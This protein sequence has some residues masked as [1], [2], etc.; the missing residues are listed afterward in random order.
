[1]GPVRRA[2]ILGLLSVVCAPGGVANAADALEC[3]RLV[4]SAKV[5]SFD[6]TLLDATLTVPP[7]RARPRPLIVFLHGLLADKK[8]YLSGGEPYKTIHWNNRWFAERGYVVL[9]YSARGHGDSGG[10]IELA[11]RHVEVRDTRFLVGQLVD[12][13][14]VDPR[15]MAVLGSSYGGG[16]A[17]LLM[18][19]REG[20]RGEYGTWRSPRGK[21]ISLAAVVPQYTW[22]DLVQSLVPNGRATGASPVGVPKVTLIDGFLASAGSRLPSYA[23]RWLSRTTAGEPYEGDPVIAEAIHALSVDRS[24]WYQDG[25]FARLRA[26]RQRPVPVFAAQGLTDPVFSPPGGGRN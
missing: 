10:E 13:G 19:T 5:P 6:G 7:G 21:P 20:D 23:Y 2:L 4:C 16:Q 1:M 22:T 15:R 12:Q 9:N 26:G 3:G 17:W 8:E 25:Y 14:L 18:T 24:A 11:S